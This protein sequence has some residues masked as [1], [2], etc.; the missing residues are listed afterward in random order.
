MIL[1]NLDM[2]IPDECW[3]CPMCVLD[4]DGYDY[5]VLLS[6]LKDVTKSIKFHYIER[7]CKDKNCPLKT[8]D[9]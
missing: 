3:K 9:K 1:I 5:C 6:E 2:E 4:K 8:L 7:H